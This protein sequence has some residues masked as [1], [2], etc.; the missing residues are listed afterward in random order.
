MGAGGGAA[1]ELKFEQLSLDS[2]PSGTPAT[3]PVVTARPEVAETDAG[4]PPSV[5]RDGR[6]SGPRHTSTVGLRSEFSGVRGTEK[7]E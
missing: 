7:R 4:A 6:T 1:S 5:G 3:C 2:F